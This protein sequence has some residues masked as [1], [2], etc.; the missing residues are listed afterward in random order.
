MRMTRPMREPSAPT[1]ALRAKERSS[2]GP[3][4]RARRHRPRGRCALKPARRCRARGRFGRAVRD[5][6]RLSVRSTPLWVRGSG[7]LEATEAASC[8]SRS[9]KAAE[10]T[11]LSG[12]TNTAP[13]V[14]RAGAWALFVPTPG[15][16][17]ATCIDPGGKMSKVHARR[18]AACSASCGRIS[19]QMSDDGGLRVHAQNQPLT[20]AT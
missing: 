6:K 7:T 15:S 10:S 18:M 14:A 17:M 12:P 2:H 9:G 8:R 16:T 1:S 4:A 20:A 5:E 13:A 11:P 3:L 19:W